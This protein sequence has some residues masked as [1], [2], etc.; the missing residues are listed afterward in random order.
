MGEG[1]ALKVL[2]Y[3]GYSFAEMCRKMCS[4]GCV[5]HIFFICI[6]SSISSPV[7]SS[8]PRLGV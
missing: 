2:M 8:G 1:L 6:S 3:M 4:V 7:G 5:G